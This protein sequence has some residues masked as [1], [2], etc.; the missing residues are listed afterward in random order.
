[1]STSQIIRRPLITTPAAPAQSG[2]CPSKMN[3]IQKTKIASAMLNGHNQNVQADAQKNPQN[4][5]IVII[6]IES[7]DK[8]CQ[9][10]DDMPP[11][12]PELSL[13]PEL[14]RPITSSKTTKPRKSNAMII[15]AP[16]N[17]RHVV[18]SHRERASSLKDFACTQPHST[19]L[20]F[21]NSD[22][23]TSS[24]SSPSH[25]SDDAADSP[26]ISPMTPTET[27]QYTKGIVGEF[28]QDLV[29][30]EQKGIEPSPELKQAA[31]PILKNIL[32]QRAIN[33]FL[34]LLEKGAYNE[35]NDGPFRVG[36]APIHGI[37]AKI[38]HQKH[39][40]SVRANDLSSPLIAPNGY[41]ETRF[42]TDFIKNPEFFD[43]LSLSFSDQKEADALLA[44]A[45][46]TLKT[47]SEET[48]EEI[49]I[50]KTAE[51]LQKDHAELIQKLR[52]IL[53]RP[54]D[55]WRY[56]AQSAFY[57]MLHTTQKTNADAH[58]MHAD[59]LAIAPGSCLFYQLEQKLHQEVPAAQWNA[60]LLELDTL[61]PLCAFVIRNAPEIFDGQSIQGKKEEAIEE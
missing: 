27:L 5:S 23:S 50:E 20:Q 51:Q 8:M 44:L 3:Q 49:V 38:A 42:I 56:E 53:K 17:Y 36:G 46:P 29:A 54:K 15:G 19:S 7:A 34:I 33:Q 32:L 25:S 24:S 59:N 47:R 37:Q 4:K 11:L 45:L 1:M 40:Q 26:T 21:I 13:P 12:V 58:K 9:P 30:M 60:K 28:I 10:Q 14:P 41:D 61:R 2:I 57:Q 22:L 48:G 6:Q 18:T 39:I 35:A 52:D 31:Y 16:T 43:L 55:E